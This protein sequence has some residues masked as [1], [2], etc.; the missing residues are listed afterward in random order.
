MEH[1]S[2]VY[3]YLQ[4]KKLGIEGDPQ[5]PSTSFLAHFPPER[6]TAFAV[7]GATTECYIR[8]PNRF[9]LDT[10]QFYNNYQEEGPEGIRAITQI[11]GQ[12]RVSDQ[13]R[14]WD[15]PDPIAERDQDRPGRMSAGPD[16]TVPPKGFSPKQ[17]PPHST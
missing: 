2:E 8:R 1:M 9:G 12:R 7:G 15:R 5:I 13:A 11:D 17:E 16:R 3:G 4:D 14:R 6:F 10:F